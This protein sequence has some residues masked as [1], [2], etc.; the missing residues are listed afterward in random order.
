M[1]CGITRLPVAISVI[2]VELTGD[3]KYLTPIIITAI[4]SCWMGA[5]ISES[6]YEALM[7]AKGLSFLQDKPPLPTRFM[8]AAQVMES[9][10]RIFQ[11][12]PKV[13]TVVQ[14]LN[15]CK[16]N[17]F[18]V[19]SHIAG[20]K[21]VVHREDIVQMLLESKLAVKESKPVR[22][23][24]W[25]TI[26]DEFQGNE[27]IR[28]AACETCAEKTVDLTDYHEQVLT[29]FTNVPFTQVYTL[30]RDLGIRHLC[31]TD[32][33]NK[34]RGVITRKDLLMYDAYA[35]TSFSRT[36][37]RVRAGTGARAFMQRQEDTADPMNKK[38]DARASTE[39]L[40]NEELGDYNP[41]GPTT[42]R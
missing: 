25:K 3:S 17:S 5:P 37:G 15:S 36:S 1:V 41:A 13:S 6:L 22:K 31:V 19:L 35:D 7:R 14:T 12:R 32:Q 8:H 21:G 9:K 24:S 18:P 27:I 23:N 33:H 16:H 28:L 30:F 39:E 11:L 20:V 26:T 4:F 2:T 38:D 34:L 29:V 10:V 42:T 40:F